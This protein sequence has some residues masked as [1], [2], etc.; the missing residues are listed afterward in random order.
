MAFHAGEYLFAPVRTQAGEVDAGVVLEAHH[1]DE[2]PAVAGYGAHASTPYGSYVEPLSL[3]QPDIRHGH[4]VFRSISGRSVFPDDRLEHQHHPRLHDQLLVE[5]FTEVRSDERHLRTLGTHAVR[6]IEVLDPRPDA[7]V[8]LDG[9]LAEFRRGHA[10][11]E[12]V[13]RGVD[14]RPPAAKLPLLLGIRDR[15]GP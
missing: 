3:T 9:G 1:A 8:G 5:L 14:D 15:R 10:G 6:Q 7:V 2:H 4:N 11:L 12:N 13:E